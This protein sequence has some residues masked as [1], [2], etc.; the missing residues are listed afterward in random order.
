[1]TQVKFS[2]KDLPVHICHLCKRPI[3]TVEMIR[4]GSL[5]FHCGELKARFKKE[6]PSRKIVKS[7]KRNGNKILMVFAV[8]AI[9]YVP[10]ILF[11]AR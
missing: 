5:Y 1:M 3:R 4:I 8:M 7:K 10:I 2:T 9:I 11:A 6:A